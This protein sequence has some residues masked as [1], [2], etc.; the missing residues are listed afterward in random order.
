M[1]K[2]ILEPYKILGSDSVTALEKMV[3]GYLQNGYSLAGPLW[4]PLPPR[5]NEYKGVPT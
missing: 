3:E 2:K 4:M 5:P 1:K